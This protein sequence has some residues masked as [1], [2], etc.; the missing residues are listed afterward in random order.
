[1]QAFRVE[2]DDQ[3]VREGF[4]V[5]R[6]AMLAH[7]EEAGTIERMVTHGIHIL[8]LQLVGVD[9]QGRVAQGQDLLCP[10]LHTRTRETRE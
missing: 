1:M 10:L 8:G 7:V 2:S 5:F 9:G 3:V 4:H 6:E